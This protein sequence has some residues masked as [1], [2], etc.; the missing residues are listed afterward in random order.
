[1][2]PGEASPAIR[3]QYSGNGS[4]A[5]YAAPLTVS[6]NASKLRVPLQ[7]YH[8]RLRCTLQELAP[9]APEVPAKHFVNLHNK[10]GG[11]LD[12]SAGGGGVVM[13]AALRGGWLLCAH[14]RGAT[15][16]ILSPF[17]SACLYMFM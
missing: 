17:G 14:R 4:R 2:R 15:V 16:C 1:M 7:V 8:G 10:A 13:N 9:R 5:T 6:T 11:A 3:I 12:A